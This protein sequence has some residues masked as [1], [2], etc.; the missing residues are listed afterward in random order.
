M[1]EDELTHLFG[2]LVGPLGSPFGRNHR[3]HPTLE[4]ALA[5]PPHRVPVHTKGPSDLNFCGA[6]QFGQAAHHV[7]GLAAVATVEDMDRGGSGEHCCLIP[8]PHE[9][10]VLSEAHPR[11]W[12]LGDQVKLGAG[13]AFDPPSLPLLGIKCNYIYPHP[14]D[15]DVPWSG[16]RAGDLK[17]RALAGAFVELLDPDDERDVRV[18]RY[19]AGVRDAGVGAVVHAPIVVGKRASG[20]ITVCRSVGLEVVWRS[21]SGAA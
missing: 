6:P 13:Q 3:C 12:F 18:Q 14:F 7:G 5:N 10:V 8:L 17:A 21:P 1:L 4:Q 2:H 9:V 20:V 11:D 15:L 19:L 16:L